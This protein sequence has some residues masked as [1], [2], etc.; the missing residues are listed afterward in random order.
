MMMGEYLMLKYFDQYFRTRLLKSK[1]EFW[2][3]HIEFKF[4]SE[5]NQNEALLV[6]DSFPLVLWRKKR[7]INLLTSFLWKK[8]KI[9]DSL[10]TFVPVQCWCL[11]CGVSVYLRR[12]FPLLLKNTWFELGVLSDSFLPGKDIDAWGRGFKTEIWIESPVD[13]TGYS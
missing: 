3:W 8:R 12:K 10:T 4:F 6:Y 7:Q 2:P 9:N 11:E 13:T 1:P 5:N